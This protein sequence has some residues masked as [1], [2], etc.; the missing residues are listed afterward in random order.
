M[1]AAPDRLVVQTGWYWD[2]EF[3]GFFVA[4]DL[5]FYS[6]SNLAVEFLEG[7][8]DVD[9]EGTLFSG[10]A[11]VAI[12]V[13]ETT[14]PL[15]DAGADLQ[16]VGSQ[17]RNDPLAILV[18]SSSA[19]ADISELRGRTIAVPDVSRDS[20]IRAMSGRGVN[21]HEYSLLPF[22]GS[23]EPLRSG[24]A[25]A[26]V[27]YVTS[28]PVDLAREGLSTR[29]FSLQQA[30]SAPLPQ[31]L[32]VIR[33]SR[34]TALEHAIERWMEASSAGWR[35]NALDPSLYPPKMR[36]TWFARTSR[37]VE[38]EVEHNRRQ[39]GFMGEPDQFLILDRSPHT[40]TP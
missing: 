15:I 36:E 18:A 11:D 19:V 25:D 8:A 40:P 29:T 13:R 38:D 17:Y 26:V 28:L 7:G 35:A 34:R 6:A 39:L 24:H 37:P 20:V 22:D 14:M 32:I 3:I 2:A 21:P 1:T 31:N 30:G 16:I 9:P 4:Q 10:T 23:A 27:G 5:G 12:T 33:R